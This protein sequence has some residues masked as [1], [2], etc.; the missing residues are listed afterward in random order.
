LNIEMNWRGGYKFSGQSMYGRE[1]STDA[2]KNSGGAED[3]YQPLELL[4]YGLAGCTGIDVVLIAGKMKQEI[5]DFKIKIDAS[6]R[7]ES[8]RAFTE[9]HIEYIFEGNNLDRAKLEKAIKLSEEKYCSAS[10]TL[11]GVTK[12]THSC[13]IKGE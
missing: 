6:Q 13:I 1:I 3:G 10:A 11:S 9:A 2:S 5:T 8:P 4:M 7:E 12:I